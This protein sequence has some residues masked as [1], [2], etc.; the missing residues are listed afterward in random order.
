MR[1]SGTITAL[2]LYCGK[3]T[4]IIMNQGKYTFKQSEIEKKLNII[5]FVHIIIILSLAGIMAGRLY[6]FIKAHGY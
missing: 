2:V 6:H 3:D 1:N 5:L 4:K